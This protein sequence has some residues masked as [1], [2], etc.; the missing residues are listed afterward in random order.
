MN[1]PLCEPCTGMNSP[2]TRLFMFIDATVYCPCARIYMY[3][4]HAC[5]WIACVLYRPSTRVT[6]GSP[7]RLLCCMEYVHRDEESQKKGRRGRGEREGGEGGKEGKRGMERREKKEK[8]GKE[9][10]G[11]INREQITVCVL[12]TL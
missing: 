7:R 8:R 3:M 5:A 12:V 10:K 11:G 9:G 1:H 6:N 2:G 4:W